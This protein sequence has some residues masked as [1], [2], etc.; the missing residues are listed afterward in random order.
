[1]KQNKKI[2]FL[3][4]AK[5]ILVFVIITIYPMSNIYARYISKDSLKQDATVAKFDV[6]ESFV[7]EESFPV[8]I[9]PGEQVNRE[10]LI[11]N[12]SDVA[13]LLTISVENITNNLPLTFNGV[14]QEILPNTKKTVT[15]GVVWDGSNSSPEYAEKVDVIKLII[16]AE[17][18]D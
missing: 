17:Q 13:I 5:L 3:T 9:K 6:S 12:N 8:S 2:N 16:R 11:N 4:I 10:I 7:A 1:M 18:I 14:N 15:V